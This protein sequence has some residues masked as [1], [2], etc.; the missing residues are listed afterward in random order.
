M[1]VDSETAPSLNADGNNVGQYTQFSHVLILSME[2][3]RQI[4]SKG[5]DHLLK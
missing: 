4:L 2:D 1:F 5:G 3:T